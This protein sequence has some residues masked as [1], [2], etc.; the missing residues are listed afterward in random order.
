MNAE[1]FE[2]TPEPLAGLDVDCRGLDFMPLDVARLRDSDL[3]AISSGDGFKAAVLLWAKSWW[4]IPAGSLL[5]N[6]RALA[7]AV[8]MSEK[9]FDKVRAEAL[10]GWILC[11]DGRLYHPVIVDFAE[12]AAKNRRNQSERA[13][14]RWAK[15]RAKKA[16]KTTTVPSPIKATAKAARNAVE[17][18]Q[19][20]QGRGRGRE[21]DSDSNESDGSAAVVAELR[22]HPAGDFN[23]WNMC[24]SVLS[25][26]GG[27]SGSSAR[28]FIGKLKS[29]FK[30]DDDGL[31]N[32]ALATW[33]EKSQDPRAF[34]RQC[35]A[36]A[37]QE[38]KPAPGE[39]QYADWSE[40]DREKLRPIHR[41]RVA[42]WLRHHHWNERAN[43]PAPD[44]K[45]AKIL[46]EILAEFGI[47]PK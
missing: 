3:V 21:R 20:M 15:E 10:H 11:S 30:L 17:Y 23:S 2:P 12:K 28:S 14:S 47:E 29:E 39:D 4:E 18:A 43:G 40:S 19:S 27:I 44:V 24:L 46:P 5:N 41:E 31:A 38:R 42:D 34:M 45:G 35:A 8:G 6:E 36:R 16:G 32:I 9:E 33:A 22:K 37:G 26:L 7:R 25:H 13:N 1:L